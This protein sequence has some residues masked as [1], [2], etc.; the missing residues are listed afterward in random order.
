MH[1]ITGHTVNIYRS[2]T[3]ERAYSIP[4]MH[5]LVYHVGRLAQERT[6]YYQLLLC[7]F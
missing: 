3:K 1:P 7:I 6:L 5:P 4:K 2:R